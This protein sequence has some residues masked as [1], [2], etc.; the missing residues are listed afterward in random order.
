M[1]VLSAFSLE[2]ETAIVTGGGQGL[3]REMALGLA[4]AGA[5][6]VVLQRHLE[7]AEKTAEDIRGLGRKSLA[8]RV[9]V[10][11]PADVKEMVKI[12][13]EKF[14]KIDI[15]INNAGVAGWVRAEEMPW[16]SGIDW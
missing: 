14:K 6:V 2:G 15:L 13:K 9:D 4:E 11:N 10:S 16:K 1:G 5:D 12:V 8:L 3:G 7:V